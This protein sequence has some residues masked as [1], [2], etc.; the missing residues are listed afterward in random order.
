MVNLCT[1]VNILGT[2]SNCQRSFLALGVSQHYA[3]NKKP[4]NCVLNIGRQSC[5]I[6]MKEK[7][8]I[9]SN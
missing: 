5:E 2:F 6:I 3:Q 7:S 4:V 8:T 1:I 9:L